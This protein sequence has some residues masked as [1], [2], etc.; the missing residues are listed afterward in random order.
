MIPVF[1]DS[2][3]KHKNLARTY[4]NWLPDVVEGMAAGIGIHLEEKDG[5]GHAYTQGWHY[6]LTPTQYH[7]TV[8]HTNHLSTATADFLGRSSLAAEEGGLTSCGSS[9]HIECQK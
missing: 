6:T 4:K 8:T 1:L 3:R 7:L 5:S 2:A 9:H